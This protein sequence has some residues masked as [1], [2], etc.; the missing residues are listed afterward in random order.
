MTADAIM[1]DN[2]CIQSPFFVVVC[3]LFEKFTS[4]NL[5]M[6]IHN[7]RSAECSSMCRFTGVNFSKLTDNTQFSLHS[8][9]PV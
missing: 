4:I 9:S 7:Y 6:T 3:A 2:D 5:P 1:T 8:L